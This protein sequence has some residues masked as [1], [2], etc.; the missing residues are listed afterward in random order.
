MLYAYN[1]DASH[2]I[3]PKYGNSALT[4]C[5]YFNIKNRFVV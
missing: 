4:G 2:T 1:S 3:K 5:I